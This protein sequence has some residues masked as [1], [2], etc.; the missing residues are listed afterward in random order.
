MEDG[1]KLLSGMRDSLLDGY[2]FVHAAYRFYST[3]APGNDVV[4]GYNAWNR[5]I[6]DCNVPDPRNRYCRHA[7]CDGVFTGLHGEQEK[8]GSGSTSPRSS[9][10]DSSQRY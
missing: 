4:F 8:T 9:L 3:L 7:D 6:T 1:E 5:F 2:A 10:H